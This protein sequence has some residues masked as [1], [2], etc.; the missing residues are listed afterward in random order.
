M[1]QIR[2]GDI[3]L[4][5]TSRPVDGPPAEEAVLAL[6]EATGH[7]HRFVGPCRYLDTG[8]GSWLDA[9]EGGV[10]RHEEH[11]HLDIPPGTY[12]VVHQ[13]EYWPEGARY[14]RD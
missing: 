9:P 12:R 7:A 6:G 2:Q 11:R 8:A 10:L 4:V 5:R 13:R 1:T 14:L 3:L